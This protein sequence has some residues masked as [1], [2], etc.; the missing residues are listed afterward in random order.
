VLRDLRLTGEDRTREAAE[1]T[2]LELHQVRAAERYYA[3]Y[4]DEVDAWIDAVDEEASSA[5]T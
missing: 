2:G 4:T 1:R 3:T 5:R